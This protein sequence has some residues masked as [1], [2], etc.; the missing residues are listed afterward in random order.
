MKHFLILSI[1]GFVLF[2]LFTSWP[3]WFSVE[4][5]IGFGWM[6]SGGFYG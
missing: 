4:F 6:F 5:G 2:E 3:W 1:L